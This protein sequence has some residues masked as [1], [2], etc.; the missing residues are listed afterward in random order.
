VYTPELVSNPYRAYIGY[1]NNYHLV[2]GILKRRYWWM[3]VDEAVGMQEW[4]SLNFL[5][6]QLKINH[7]YGMQHKAKS[8]IDQ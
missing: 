7:F 5:W 6:T 1:G 4:E 3:V 2:K 8:R